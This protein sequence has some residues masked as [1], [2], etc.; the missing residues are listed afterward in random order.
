MFGSLGKRAHAVAVRLALHYIPRSSAV[1]RWDARTKLFG[2]AA[3]TGA[4]LCGKPVVFGVVT[5]GFT[6]LLAA[7]RLPWHLPL[8]TIRAWAPFLILLFLVQATSWESLQ[9]LPKSL[10]EV[11]PPPSV[12]AA[13]V[14]LW[15]ITL[16]ILWAVFFTATTKTSEVQ[17]AVLWVL[18]P[19]PF[20]PARRIAVMAG[21]S[22]RLFA[23]L[24]DDLEEIRTACRAR[25]ADRS[26][27]P[28]RRMKTVI[29]PL[30][31]KALDR[32]ESTALAL[33][34]R[35]YRDD[36]PVEVP[37]WPRAEMLSCLLLFGLLATLHGV[38]P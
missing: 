36:V 8:R 19:F 4:L 21:L 14:S 16:M 29:L 5:G 24:L 6:V 28:Y 33:A 30:F 25:L 13:A 1:H 38:L 26:K 7:A 31:R 18:R 22:M 20:V 35:G 34:A 23:T 3:V 10:L 17:R 11:F 15:R 12:T 27:N 9:K 2:I 32:A 37:P